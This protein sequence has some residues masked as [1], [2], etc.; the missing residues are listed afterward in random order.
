MAI[1]YFS[2]IDLN[3]NQLQNAAIGTAGSAPSSPVEGQIYF[4]T[5]DSKLYINTSTDGSDGFTSLMP[6]TGDITRVNI[7]AGNG[8]GGTTDTTSGAHTQTLSLDNSLT[9]VHTITNTSLI[10]ARDADN[11]IKLST[12]NQ[13]IF[14]VGAND[15]VTF[16]ASG[17][18][19]ATSLDIGSGGVDVDGTL[20]ANTITIGDANILTGG[21]VTTLGTISQDTVTFTSANSTDPLVII[22]NTTADEG[23]ARLQFVKDKGAAGAD[24]DIIGEVIFTG[25]DAAQTQTNFAKILVTVSEADNTDEAGKLQLQVA[26]SNGTTTGLENGLLLTGHK[27]GDYVDVTLGH[28]INSTTTVAGN[29]IVS[30]ITTTVDSTTVATGDAM[31]E[32]AKDQGTSADAVDFGFYGVYG[33]SSTAKYAGVFRDVSATGDPFTFFDGLRVKPTTTVDTGGAGYDLADISAGAITAADGFT[34]AINLNSGNLTIGGHSVND[35]DIGSQF[36]DADDHLMSSGAIK[37]KIESYSY[38]TA[39]S[40]DTLSNKTIAISQVTELS[41]LTDHEG[42]QL[43]NIGGTT[44]ISATQWGYLGAASG[45]ITNT[46]TIDMGDGFVIEDGD[47]TEVTVTENKQVKFVEGGN[48]DI[49]FTDVNSGADGDEF[50]L[51]FAVPTAA[52]NVVGAVELAL[53]SEV[54]PGTDSSRAV[55]ADSLA[56]RT[57]VGTITKTSLSTNKRVQITHSLGTEDLIVQ[58]FDAS[59]KQTVYADVYRMEDD[60][61]TVSTNIITV[62][63]GNTPTNNVEFVITS[64]AGA[65][66]TTDIVYT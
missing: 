18:I 60:L 20:E 13:I 34:G 10:L 57:V 66:V 42:A 50:D 64:G 6:N 52:H 24:G 3:K 59:T 22:K 29:L 11:K 46:D 1:D 32:L 12:D 21:I 45:A 41:N 65:T 61:T 27:T 28:G 47:G 51:T 54:L 48:I 8:L 38:I 30:G 37:E 49:N 7:T 58:L 56:A 36:V 40:S 2:S 63:F 14:R 9:N 19:E 33:E 5:G 55:T 43:E 17:E 4:N 39:S 62:D 25:D 26:A 16:K 15:G 31:L 53:A 35:I 23:G 44:T